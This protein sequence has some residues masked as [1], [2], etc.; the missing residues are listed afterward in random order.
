VTSDETTATSASRRSHRS[1]RV[2][3]GLTAVVVSLGF[4]A[5]G[6]LA[7]A[8]TSTLNWLGAPPPPPPLPDVEV[9][10][11]LVTPTEWAKNHPDNA[12]SSV[13]STHAQTPK[14][15]SK[16]PLPSGQ[17]VAVAPGNDQKSDDAKYLA[18]HDNHVEKETRARETTPFYGKAMAQATTASTPKAQA[19]PMHMRG[20]QGSGSVESAKSEQTHAAPNE[21]PKAVLQPKVAQLEKTSE[22]GET[23][24]RGEQAK[25]E[26][27]S[28]Q[29][30]VAPGTLAAADN[31]G[32]DGKAGTAGAE[33][34]STQGVKGATTG[35]A[36][37]DHLDQV[38]IGDG[39]FLNTREFKYASFFNR[40]K[41]K[42]G[43][44]WH[45]EDAM[46][47]GA[48]SMSS[49]NRVT[50][51]DV[52]LDAEGRIAAI[53]VTQSCGFDNLDEE[54]MA[55]FKRAAPFYNVPTGLLEDDHKMRFRFSFH[56]ENNPMHR[57]GGR[58]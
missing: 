4:H 5:V 20:N 8:A 49:R 15:T 14:D 7:I 54:A 9:E 30:L 29:L 12:K 44:Q 34:S 26:G 31:A 13:A 28:K 27:N 47:R 25:T 32:S 58:F 21:I 33:H 11:A 55:A 53:E 43:E 41:Q 24:A 40:V 38:P 22:D 10:T 35:A 3:R 1:R 37:N 17:I 19:E 16:A 56:I 6:A 36:A 42:V 18:E 52:V 45:I 2:G 39:T 23:K 48:P 46:R 50:V 57:L 51:V